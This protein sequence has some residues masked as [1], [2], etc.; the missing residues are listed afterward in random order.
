MMI[1]NVIIILLAFALSSCEQAS[2][3]AP[4]TKATDQSGERRGGNGNGN[5]Q[6]NPNADPCANYPVYPVE[7]SPVRDFNIKVDTT[8]CGVVIFRWDLQEG[9]NPVTDTCYT[10]A[11]YYYIS[12]Q[13]VGHTNGCGPNGGSLSSTNS[14]YYFLGAGC[15]L[16][17]S[18]TY[19]VSITYVERNTTLQKSIWHSSLPVTF[20]AGTRAPWLNNCI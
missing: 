15:S 16:F 10:I 8:I 1:K 2:E 19:N 13:N 11:R 7:Y 12:F 18:Y 17:P 14:Y 9:F 20:T 6:G 5:G 4:K 3:V